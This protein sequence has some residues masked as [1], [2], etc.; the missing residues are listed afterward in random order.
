MGFLKGIVGVTAILGVTFVITAIPLGIGMGA[1][2]L[3]I[4]KDK[5][6]A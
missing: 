2:Y 5:R 3:M 1:L 6:K 4:P